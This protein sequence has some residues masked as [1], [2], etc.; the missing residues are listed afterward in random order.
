M[1]TFVTQGLTDIDLLALAGRDPESKQ[2]FHTTRNLLTASHPHWQAFVD[3]RIADSRD[4]ID[5][6]VYS[7]L[8][9]RLAVNRN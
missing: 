1:S 7:T 6:Y 9:Q 8:L 3:A 4:A 5:L 2:L